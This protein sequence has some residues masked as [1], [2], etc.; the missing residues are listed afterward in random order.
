VGIM[1]TSK[2][3][4]LSKALGAA[5]LSSGLAGP[6]NAS[7]NP[8]DFQTNAEIS[9]KSF[10]GSPDLVLDFV[11]LSK[12]TEIDETL[13]H[14]FQDMGPNQARKLP[15][16][17][18]SVVQLGLVPDKSEFVWSLL[19][20]LESSQNVDD[21]TFKDVGGRLVDLHSMNRIATFRVAQNTIGQECDLNRPESEIMLDPRCVPQ[22][23]YA[24]GPRG[25]SYDN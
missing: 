9:Q 18:L 1:S 23:T 8:V 7:I 4:L 17:Y 3:L 6:V 5:A 13:G 11:L 14:M 10:V 19:K 24:I 2:K 25:G 12:Q 22:A 15:D 16:F 20:F 21:E